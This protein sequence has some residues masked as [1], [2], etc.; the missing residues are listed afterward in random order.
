M[1]MSLNQQL[2]IW[3]G[4]H[5]FSEASKIVLFENHNANLSLDLRIFS[6]F[7]P[8][9]SWTISFGTSYFSRVFKNGLIFSDLAWAWEAFV[10]FLLLEID[11]D[12]SLLSLEFLRELVG[13]VSS[14]K[15]DPNSFWLNIQLFHYIFTVFEY[16]PCRKKNAF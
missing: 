6:Q 4:Y 11:A 12:G 13:I 16:C 2:P 10:T 8:L 5:S 3:H 9:I 7:W 1:S 15:N 14:S